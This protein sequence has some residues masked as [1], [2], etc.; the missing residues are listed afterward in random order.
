MNRLSRLHTSLSNVLIVLAIVCA[1]LVARAT[2]VA[3]PAIS[4]AAGTYAGAQTVTITDSTSGSTIYYTTNGNTPT[5]SSTVYRGPITVSSSETLEAMATATGDTQS[6][7]ATAPYTILGVLQVYISAPGAGG[8]STSVPGALTETFDALT[9][10]TKYT[11]AYVSTAGIGTY[12]SSTQQFA[13]E[14]PG[15]FGGATDTAHPSSGTNYFAVGGDSTSTSPVYLTLT[16]PVSYFGFWWSAGDQYNTVALYSGS[17][18]YGTFTTA[19]LLTFLNHGTGTITASSGATYSTSAYFG[20]PN[21][22][23][24]N[25]STEPFAYISFVISGATIDNIAFYNTSTSTSFESDNHSA[26]FTG[27]PVT[28]P[29]TFVPVETMSLGTQSV[30]VTVS[31]ASAN[32]KAGGTQQFTATVV[33]S[34]NT[35]V[36]WSISPATG[37]GTISSSGLYTAPTTVTTPQTVTITATSAAN[38][39]VKAPVI[40]NL[41]ATPT[42]S[43]WP[44]A[45]GITYGQT[46]ASSTLT[47]GTT[48]TPG[49]FTWTTPSTAPGV[50]TA[51]Q[52]VTFTPTASTSYSIV[53]GTVSVMV[54]QGT[55]V[56]TFTSANTVVYGTTLTVAATSTLGTPTFTEANGTGTATL[57]GSTLTP[58]GVGTVTI[59]AS[60]A[61]TTNYKAASLQQTVTITPPP[62]FTLTATPSTL[63]I[64]QGASGTS[65][66]A[67]VPANGFTGSVTL[68]A[69]GLPTG[70]TAAFATNPTTGSS[71]LTLTAS[72]TATVGTATVTITGTSGSLTATKT[73]ALTISAPPSFTLTATPSTL[74]ILQGASGTST[75]A[76]VPANG[77]TGSV[78][79][80]AS[81]LPT[82]VTA[83]FATNPTTGSSVLTLTASGTATVGT[84]TVTIAGTSGS[85]TATKTIALTIGAPPSFTLTA[86]PS[87]LSILQGASGTS[88]IAVV[89]ANGFTGSVS[90]AAFGL[91][92]GVT[93]SFATNPTTSSSVL[94]LTASSTATVGTATVTVTGTSGSLTA[95]TTI[96]LNIA[97]WQCISSYQRAIT[98]DH[99]KVP[100]TDQINFPFLFS[101][102][103][104]AFA[105]IANGGHVFSSTGNDIVFSSDP[106]GATALDYELE[107]YNPAT[108]QVIAWIRIPTL[109]HTADTVIYMFYGNSS[110]AAP[111]QNPA[112]VWDSH[113]GGVWHL[114]QAGTGTVLSYPDST[115]NANNGT[116]NGSPFS[117]SGEVG[118]ALDFAGSSDDLAI[119]SIPLNGADY[120]VSAWINTPL[121]NN[122]SWNTLTRG[123]SGDHQVIVNESN[124]HLGA[125]SSAAASFEDSGFAINSLPNGWHHLTASATGG[126][127]TYYVDGSPVG[128][129]PFQSSADIAF[130]GN[131]QG[132]GQ[133]FGDADEI[134]IS[135]G[136]ARSA[137]W[138]ATEY[139]NESS[140]ASFYALSPDSLD[141]TEQVT[142]AA[143]SLYA[144]QNQPFAMLGVGTCSSVAVNWTINPAVG[145]IN[146]TGLYSAPAAISTKQTITVT[147]TNQ[148]NNL[149]ASATV[150]LMQSSIGPA[151]TVFTINGAGFGGAEGAS[152]VTVG[153][154]P[155][156]TLFWSDTQIQAQVPTGTGLGNQNVVVTVGGQTISNTTFDVTAGLTGISITPSAT[157]IPASVTIDTPG[158]TAPLIFQGT[159][160]QVAYV[161]ISN[162]T[163]PPTSP[164]DYTLYFSIINNLDNSSLTATILGNASSGQLTPVLLPVTGTYTVFLN[165]QNGSTGSAN[166][167]LWLSNRLTGTITSG[168]PVPTTINIPGQEQLLTFS[169]TAG[170]TAYL[171]ISNSTFLPASPGDYTLYF[172]IINNLDN[173]S[174]IATIIGNTSFGQLTPIVLPVTGTYTVFVNPQNGSTG[175]ATVSLW[176]SNNLV[177]TIWSGIPV[178]V[179]ISIP[180]QEERLTFG[181][182]EGQVANVQISNSTF[183]PTAP[184]NY[185]LYFSMINN[186]D[187]STPTATFM[188]SSGSAQ[189]NPVV[190]PATGTY[191]VFVDP[192]LGSTGSGTVSLTLTYPT[193]KMSASL[194]PAQSQVG[195]PVTVNL[196]LTAT[197]GAVPTGTV[198]C[199]GVGVTSSPATVNPNG[200]AT[201]Q[202]NGLPVGND[203]IICSFASSNLLSFSNSASYPMIESV[204]PVPT[205]GSVSVTPASA[206]L[207]AGQTLQFSASVF[208]TSNQA[209]TW[210]LPAG[211]PGTYG[212]LTASGLYTAPASIAMQETVAITA[213]GQA[214]GTSSTTVLVTLLPAPLN[215]ALTLSA[216]AELPYVTGTIQSFVAAF[217]DRSGTPI[218][219]E[220]VTF[221][222]A[223]AN[224]TSGTVTT[225]ANGLATFTY[226]GVKSGNDTIQ[227]AANVSG[228]QVTSNSV[229]AVWIVPAEPV[230]TTGVVGQFFF[231][232][233][234]TD[235]GGAGAFNTPPTAT[236]AFTQVFPNICFNPPNG[237]I[238]GNTS[239]GVGTHPFTDVTTDENGNFTGTIIAQGNGYQAGWN[240]PGNGPAGFVPNQ[241]I[242]QAVF[243]GSYVVAS[244]GD[245]V[246]NVYVDNSFILGIGGGATRVSGPLNPGQTT[247]PFEQLPV[248]GAAETSIGG[249]SMTVHFPGPGTYPY[250]LDYLECCGEGGTDTLSLMMSMGPIGSSGLPPAAAL[251]ITPSSLNPL[252]AGGQQT[253]TVQATDASG[254]PVPNLGVALE[255]NG[256]DSEELKA[257]TNASGSA[258]FTYQNVN[259]GIASAQ[260][261]AMIDG[262]VTFSNQ[263]SVPWTLPGAATGGSGTL[264]LSITADSTVSLPNALQLTGTATDS[265]L[266]AGSSPTITWSEFSGPGTITFTPSS[267]QASATATFRVPGNYV[268]ELSASDSVPNSGFV[269]WPVTVNPAQQDPQGWIGSPTYGSSVSGIVPI[270]LAPGV[271]L[272]NGATLSYYPA[273]NPTNITILPIAAQSGTI[274][275]LDTTTLVNG[276]YWILLQATDTTGDT[277]YSLVSVSVAGNYKPGRVTATVTDLVVPATGL[278]I[279]IQRTY[280]S[281]NAATSSDFGYG[282]SLG[283]N[284]NLVVDPAGNVTFTLGGQRKTFYFTPQMPGCSPLLGCFF[285]YYFPAYTPESGLHGTLT[286]SG[287]G[288]PALDIL[289]PDGNVW[290]CQTGGQYNP[291]G[292]IY[293]DPNGTSYTI[294]AA[295]NLQ[296]IQDLSG[297][298]L[299]I[300]S[301]GITSTTGLN[302]QFKRDPNNNNRITKIT[303]TAGNP[304]LYGYDANGNLSTVTY[305]VS[306]QSTT[307][308]PGNT[309]SGT[310]TYTYD[311]IF[312]HLYAGGV[313]GRGCPLPASTYFPSGSVDT[314]GN[315]LAGR[316]QSVTDAYNEKTSYAYNIPNLTTTIT[317]PDNNTATMVYDSFGDLLSSTDPNNITTTNTYDA[318][319]NL[320]SVT[321]PRDATTAYTTTYTYDANGNK[322][323]TTY[324]STGTGHNTTSSTYYNQYSEPTSTIDELGNVRFFNYDT[325]FL[326]QSVTDS[327]G[328]LASFV[329][330]P[331]STLAAGAIGFD[332]TANPAQASQFTY[333]TDGNMVSRTDAL[334]RTT[335]YVYNALGQ[336][337]SMT[338]PT[339]TSLTGSAAST[340]T[341]G[342]D[343]MG[344][345]TSTA[346]PLARST[347]SAYDVNGNKVSDTDARGN[348]TY[349]IYD[350]LNR[351]VETDYP[352]TPATKS[353]RTYDFRNNVLTETDQA[354][355]VTQH[356]YDAGGRQTSVTRGSG[357]TTSTTSYTYYN[358][359]RKAT[360]TDPANNVTT[361]TYDAAGRL[362][363]VS[364]AQG[365][366][367][368]GY[369]DAG[370]RTSSTD[371][372]SNKT[373]FQYDARKR[374]TE[375]DYPATASYPD[376]TSVKNTYDGPGNLASVTDQA[377]NIVNYTYDAANQ[378]LTVVQHNSPSQPTLTN[379]YNYDPLGSLTSLEDARSNTTQNLFDQYGEPTQKT[380]P[381]TTLTESRTYDPAGNLSTLTHFNNAVTTYAYDALNRLLSR[382]T[383]SEP[384]DSVSFTYTAT[385]KYKTSTAQDGTV[386]Y[387]YDTLDRLATKVTPEGTLSY[388]YFPTGKVETIVSSNPHGVNESLTYD[389]Q[390]RLATVVDGNLSGPNTTTYSYDDAS[391]V[392][393][394][395]IPNGLT[396]TFTY[397]ALNRLTELST[398]PI[399]DYKYTLGA[400][401]IRTNATEQSGRAIQWSYDNIYRLNGETITGDPA[402]NSGDNGSA[403]YTLDPVGN[404][405]AET[406][407]LSGINP[408]AGSYN[409]NDQLSSESYDANGNTTQTANGNQYTYDS[410]NH[411]IKMVNGTTVV[412]MQ[413]DAFG[414]RVAKTVGAVTT[415]YLV[416][417]DVNPT[418]YP[419]VVEEL[420]NGAVTRQYTYGLQR[421]SEN[422]SPLVTGN[423]TWTPSFYGYDG[424]GSV[425]Q[426]TNSSGVV[427]D[428]YEYDAFGNSF[429]KSGTTPNNYLYRGEQY[430]SDLALYYLRARYYNPSTGRFLSRDPEDGKAKDPASL[431]KYLYASG[432]PVN[433]IDPTGRFNLGEYFVTAK[434]ILASP[435]FSLAARAITTTCLV[436][437]WRTIAG[438]NVYADDLDKATAILIC[439]TASSLAFLSWAASL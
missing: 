193:V 125:F 23:G 118:G 181:G 328:T 306:A 272:Q 377:G 83:A 362:I 295:G 351:L 152:S 89:G 19:N 170:Q 5:T 91:P 378:L 145:M 17:T 305:P 244:A 157:G 208:N 156:V 20:N 101:A 247:T 65:T 314:S 74:S 147:A 206:T 87:T 148:A 82:G 188:S 222:V 28:I 276:T 177:G 81:G 224:N 302:V 430:D 180:G 352:T 267:S 262:M 223:G 27:S 382:T 348:T 153:G 131:Y 238:P 325:N 119:R 258:S 266:P 99:T 161:Q 191:T 303:D 428:S 394:V 225:D 242:F 333:D 52:S 278:A 217:K 337:T 144:S 50:G 368:Y 13:I 432:D 164:G 102:T 2:T 85:L 54:G 297:N 73:I 323:S 311:Q 154:L 32:V 439:A 100:N 279:N 219:G 124:W 94:T 349:Y 253:F 176:L 116:V 261:V 304:Y 398:S 397:D 86:T 234:Q 381:T 369:D 95:S 46:L 268:I 140:P 375:T 43:V 425:R 117:I 198:T 415:Q 18:L 40:V 412:T 211:A 71:V 416:E 230:S 288:C 44:T 168:V 435:A 321:V 84:A 317:Y 47:G 209:V 259:P 49:T 384:S 300:T 196:T 414:N 438:A 228:E 33:G 292:Y 107:E 379:Q 320:T 280:D 332:I 111:E 356:V 374:L 270:S 275:T 365:S 90:L 31:P 218:A 385:G 115:V 163:F 171:N 405:T 419:Q 319:H 138:I 183:L 88:T 25:D 413:Y 106:T 418:G 190:L 342:Y 155:A 338:T 4:L 123:A 282:W 309:A 437:T 341:Y 213:T 7:T 6:G 63:S 62:S 14:A 64:L 235:A 92:S 112:G 34:T 367:Q 187:N 237:T 260:A 273:S 249:F 186:Q 359:G 104:W 386:S 286:D 160:G 189:L 395:K 406:S 114:N 24:T 409:P 287:L 162:S 429:S 172:S 210:S 1:P 383:P 3:T 327:I 293:T 373:S 68:A 329:F 363:Q 67:V 408:I 70:V 263:V 203:A 392:A 72:G 66:I 346:A 69:S 315:S 202:M 214:S 141:S 361:Y 390:N 129:I 79:L 387:T 58:T 283:I 252:P 45:S 331:N 159:A 248:M 16:H 226:A 53:T 204:I 39:T 436:N 240:E 77:F 339:P 113:Y 380:L 169:G 215:P 150:T 371:G 96:A 290:F 335:S 146:A 344:N 60:V 195:N 42:V 285:P 11:T 139:S 307:P 201:V 98:I 426:L 108:G 256:A 182:I 12:G 265:G 257:T 427:T 340:T 132:G 236:P 10:N 291:P 184:G 312:I 56:I 407:S 233:P 80:A 420:V 121:P 179:T 178:P 372:N 274:A 173:S 30:S 294:S 109:S 284:V 336:K 127:T 277:Q 358:D 422:L 322:T 78:T 424:F 142:P 250:E 243:T 410:E 370:N 37:A 411:L 76:V 136:I 175:S 120:T 241:G 299:T 36:T 97:A 350:A 313:D 239:I 343:A 324:P 423:N 334:G 149:S 431:H 15:E 167:N 281:L 296:S 212:T 229:S 376:G 357:S 421:I 220:A 38:T 402:N 8:E 433:G 48:S 347:S 298:G 391:N 165:P 404:R 216:T 9:A 301:S 366:M 254:N 134:Q 61:A 310:S 316:L 22:T 255:I 151:G 434:K 174:L 231:Y 417:D 246:I 400:T 51:S 130:L 269:K 192:Q 93:A 158:Q 185:A 308:C 110:I 207:Y 364:G 388:T 396:S 200:T 251:T 289:I 221:T 271:T 29:A 135:T 197:N 57:S 227:A 122:G 137:D 360:E 326:P 393:T 105:T 353:T 330:N 399:T 389:P 26:I 355:N 318:N 264:A 199:T 166:I 75:I 55:P 21:I 126:T 35:S 245:A 194:V 103:D 403:S 401:G 128:T 133:Q 205:T 143:V 232:D 41:L 354:N 59:T 345:L